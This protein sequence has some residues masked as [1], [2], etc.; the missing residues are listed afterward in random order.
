M[1]QKTFYT[2]RIVFA[3]LVAAVCS[4]AV[5]QGNYILPIVV[6]ITAAIALYMMKKRVNG[7][8]ADERDYRNAGDAARWSLNIYA[9]FAA[10][11]A[12]ILMAQRATDFR[13]ELAAQILAYSACAL[14]IMQ[15]LLFKYF[16]NRK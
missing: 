2:V 4:I 15:S 6:G 1:N 8:M 11:V 3:M 12:M 13:Y 7:V 5:V 14:M 10:I 16:Q 9:V